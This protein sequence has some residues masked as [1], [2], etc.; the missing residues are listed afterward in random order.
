M[1]NATSERSHRRN[2]ISGIWKLVFV[3]LSSVSKLSP[4]WQLPLVAHCCWSAGTSTSSSGKW[5]GGSHSKEVK[6]VKQLQV[7]M[8]QQCSSKQPYRL[9][10]GSH[11]TSGI[12]A[13]PSCSNTIS[14][15]VVSQKT[16]AV[17]FL[18]GRHRLFLFVECL[19]IHSFNS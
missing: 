15:P 5:T 19:R 8:L 3:C 9:F 16:V 12:S 2:W 18:A 6:A 1:L 17:S 13:I 11:C 4:L 10:G 7:E 14:N